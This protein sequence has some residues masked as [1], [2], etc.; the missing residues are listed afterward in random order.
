MKNSEHLMFIYDRMVN[1]H[2]ENEHFDY[3]NK[4]RNVIDEAIASEDGLAN[5]LEFKKNK[6]KLKIT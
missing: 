1:V 6:D 2:G 5:Y 4:F 3:M